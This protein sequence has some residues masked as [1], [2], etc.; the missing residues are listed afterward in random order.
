[1]WYDFG[2]FFNKKPSIFYTGTI[3]GPNKIINQWSGSDYAMVEQ[4]SIDT[5]YGTGTW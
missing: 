2:F 1:M 3:I 5:G 4:K